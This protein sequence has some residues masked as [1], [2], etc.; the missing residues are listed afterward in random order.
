[1]KTDWPF[2]ESKATAEIALS[3]IMGGSKPV[4]YVVHTADDDLQRSRL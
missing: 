1:M 3:R 4:L 2:K